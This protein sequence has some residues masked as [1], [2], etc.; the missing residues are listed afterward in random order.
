VSEDTPSTS[1]VTQAYSRYI[2]AKAHLEGCR[3]EC[4]RLGLNPDMI[5]ELF[6]IRLAVAA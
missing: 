3:Q 1:F 6:N 5:E 2:D 4:L